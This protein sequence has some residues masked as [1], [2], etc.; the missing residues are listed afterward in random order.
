MTYALYMVKLLKVE[1]KYLVTPKVVSLKL[2]LSLS[3]L[4]QGLFDSCKLV[5]WNSNFEFGKAC[6]QKFGFITCLLENLK[7][8]HGKAN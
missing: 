7:M 8:I 6:S 4:S 3:R 2:S 1:V 5:Y